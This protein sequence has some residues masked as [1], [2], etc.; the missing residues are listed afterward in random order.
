MHQSYYIA[1]SE[2]TLSDE[3]LLSFEH[4]ELALRRPL[5][6]GGYFVDGEMLVNGGR[7]YNNP[8]RTLKIGG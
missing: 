4:M 5:G 6:F 1:V 3:S 8:W 2:G 7:D